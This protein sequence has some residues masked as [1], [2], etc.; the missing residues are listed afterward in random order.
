MEEAVVYP[1]LRWIPALPLIGFLI[2]GLGA[3]SNLSALQ[4]Q[5]VN[6]MACLA[7]F[8]AFVISVL[9]FRELLSLPEEQ[10]LLTDTVFTWISSGGF[11]A[12]ITFACQ[13]TVTTA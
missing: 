10:R 1:L 3:R 13:I 11:T 5:S 9:A 6:W 8:G 2:N 4:T 12:N 7:P